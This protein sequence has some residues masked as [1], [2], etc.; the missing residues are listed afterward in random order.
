VGK[1]H[2]SDIEGYARYEGQSTC[3]PTDKPGAIALRNLLLARYKGT[4]N[5]GISRACGSDRSEHYEGRAFDWGANVNNPS[6]KAAA[7]DFIAQLMATD[8]A[9]HMA[10]L[11]RRMGIM[12]VIWNRQI[13][14]PGPD[15]A[16]KPYTGSSPHTDHVHISLSW[17]GARLETSFWSGTVVPGLPGDPP[18][19][20]GPRQWPTA[21][22]TV[23]PRTTST[24]VRPRTTSTTTRP[25]TTTTAKPT[26]T[27]VKPTTTT[28]SQPA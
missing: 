25:T 5:Y 8:S 26:T 10:A 9:G 11:A 3:D 19:D 4:A 27:T 7:D 17:A 22:T 18:P 24:T 14:S 13:W 2:G 6:Q 21:S 20:G 12:Y 28:T 16:W 15:A 23:T 1:G